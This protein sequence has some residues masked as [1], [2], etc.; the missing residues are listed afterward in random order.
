M[1]TGDLWPEPPGQSLPEA[2]PSAP[3]SGSLV[4][5][6]AE[7]IGFYDTHY[8]RVVRFMMHV[9]ASQAD[10]QDAAQ[11]AFTESWKLMSRDP[12]AWQA[13]NGKAAWVRTTALRRH[14]RPPGSRRRPPTA[15]D[16]G[17]PDQS[18]PGPD[19]AELTAQ[20]QAVLHALRCLD[21]EARTASTPPT[22]PTR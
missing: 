18:A 9:G 15:G 11:E 14:A 7:W 3:V 4:Q 2:R 21:S 22:P 16:G 8:H 17:I 1:T 10:A 12:D 13:I 19:H 6:R 5:V 20:I